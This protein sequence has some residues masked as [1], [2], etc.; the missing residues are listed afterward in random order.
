[1]PASLSLQPTEREPVPWTAVRV[2]P[3]T[4]ADLPALLTFSEQLRD[5]LLPTPESKRSRGSRS[6]LE[7]RYLDAIADPDRHL[8][9]AVGDDDAALGMALMTVAPA[10]A[11]LDLPAL[12]VSHVVVADASKRR[13]A[14]KALVAE[15]ASYA[16]ARGIEQVV[17]SVNP[18]S[19][20]ANR[21]FARLGFA[22]LAVRRVAPVSVIRRRLQAADAVTADHVVRLRPRRGGR[23]RAG[24]A[25]LPLGPASDS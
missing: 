25:A 18:G 1:V 13:G 15:A 16:E 4:A 22:P 7:S 2:R 9:L 20:D 12:H 19:R 14:G 6:S 5:Q 3:A 24:T 21:F 8:V 23:L 17:V 11:L 10:N